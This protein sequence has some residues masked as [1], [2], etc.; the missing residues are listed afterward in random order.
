MIGERDIET[1][2][3]KKREA[4]ASGNSVDIVFVHRLGCLHIYLV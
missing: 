3:E 1:E 4:D 2:E